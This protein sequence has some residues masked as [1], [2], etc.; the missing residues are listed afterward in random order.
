MT[1]EEMQNMA[2][3]KIPN[4]QVNATL[5]I[6]R[7]RCRSY[8]R[9]DWGGDLPEVILRAP[10]WSNA[11]NGICVDPCIAEIYETRNQHR[12]GGNRPNRGRPGASGASIR[13]RP[14]RPHRI[15]LEAD[16]PRTA[17]RPTLTFNHALSATLPGAGSAGL[18]VVA[19]DS[20]RPVT[21]LAA[22]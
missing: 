20:S 9:P 12:D 17:P 13:W 11:S 16:L 19:D 4:R 21:E 15:L 1:H 18:C 14:T 10:K 5:E 22:P 6:G 8:N 2:D 7:C 3:S